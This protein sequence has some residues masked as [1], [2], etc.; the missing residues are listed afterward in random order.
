MSRKKINNKAI[1]DFYSSPNIIR[2][3]TLRRRRKIVLVNTN[4]W[5][6]KEYRGFEENLKEGGQLECPVF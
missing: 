4:R 3:I 1:H 5:N 2:L 6:V